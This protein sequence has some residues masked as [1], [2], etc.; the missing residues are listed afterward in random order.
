MDWAVIKVKEI[1]EGETLR[2]EVME[3]LDKVVEEVHQ[4]VED[5][6]Q[7]VEEVNQ[8]VEEVDQVVEEVD[9]G[10]VEVVE[11]VVVEGGDVEMVMVEETVMVGK[12]D[13]EILEI[14]SLSK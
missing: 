4:W 13:R 9:Q 6:D 3:E 14:H 1:V 8:V 12:M 11:V 10:V 5:V 7:V 2:E